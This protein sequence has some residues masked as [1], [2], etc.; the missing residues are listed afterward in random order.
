MR[1]QEER[2]VRIERRG[3]RTALTIAVVVLGL[4]GAGCGSSDRGTAR[5]DSTLDVAYNQ[6]PS[7]LDPALIDQASEWLVDFA[8]DPL[9]GMD[10]A[11]KPVPA[12]AESWR[13][14]GSGNR[15]FE[16]TLRKGVRFSDG[17][18]LTAEGVK[19]HLDYVRKANGPNAQYLAG[20]RSITATGPLTVR[21][22]LAV[23]NPLMATMLSHQYVVGDVISPKA[24]KS[25]ASLA[26]R[27]AGAGPYVLDPGATVSG[28]HY[29]YRRNPGYWDPEAV[30]YDRVVVKVIANANSTLNALKTGQV[31]VAAG[32]FTTVKGATAAGLTVKSTPQVAVGLLLADRDGQQ[33]PALGDVRVRQAINFAID[34]DAIVKALFGTYGKPTT[35]TTNSD[36]YDPALDG[37]YPYDPERAKA[38]LAQA[39]YADGFTLPVL[40]T[41][42]MSGDL[43]TQAIAG[44]LEQ[45]G[46]HVK[47]KSVTNLTQYASDLFGGKAPAAIMGYGSQPMYLEG[48]GLYLPKAPFNPFGSTD[49]QVEA[50]Y[51]QLTTAPSDQVVAASRAIEKRLVELGWFAPVGFSPLVYYADASV[52]PDSLQTSPQAPIPAI[53]RVR[54]AA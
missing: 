15:V 36:G 6:P 11:G 14:V 47:A 53:T 8:Y 42:L 52:D 21:I 49:A 24:L 17:A 40:S 50:L 30:H 26:K 2:P 54:P 31:E 18:P 16:L 44:Q 5:P 51:A 7:R 3:R 28:D 46:I 22:D 43:I 23:P 9:I 20:V 35:Q 32:D 33:V 19:A 1:D 25:P 13:Y 34:R 29:T 45:V 37:Y 38:L 39:G 12:L 4:A 27:T 41:A 48:P 10:D